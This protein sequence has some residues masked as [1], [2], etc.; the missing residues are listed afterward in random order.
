MDY[1]DFSKKFF[2]DELKARVAE[3]EARA[4]EVKARAAEVEARAAEVEARVA[5]TK[6]L[7]AD[8]IRRYSDSEAFSALLKRLY[9]EN[10]ARAFEAEAGKFDMP[11]SPSFEASVNSPSSSRIF[12]S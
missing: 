3:V 1:S 5:K 4:D 7:Y 11:S 12:S 9:V 6:I 8:G 10:E 2:S